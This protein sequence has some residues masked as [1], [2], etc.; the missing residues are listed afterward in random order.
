MA[1]TDGKVLSNQEIKDELYKEI[2]LKLDISVKGIDIDREELK[3]LDITAGPDLPG[4]RS[5]VLPSWNFVN[6]RIPESRLGGGGFEQKYIDPLYGLE[7]EDGKPYVYKY[8]KNKTKIGEV[9]FKEHKRPE[10]LNRLTS[11][12]VPFYSI[13]S[14]NDAGQVHVNYSQICVLKDKGEDCYFCNYNVRNAT[15]KNPKQVAEVF[16]ELYLAGVGKHLNLTSGFMQERR[17][18]E[19]YLDVGEEIKRRTGLKEFRGT[20]VI[21]APVDLSQIEKYKEAGFYSVRMNIEIWDKNIWRAICPG[22]HNH[23]GGWDNWVKALERA[24]EVFGK[25]R[26][27]SNIVGGIESKKSILEGI[28]YETSRGI[29][30]SAS[31]WR[32]VK[33]S[34][35]EGHRTPETYWHLDLQKKIAA[36]YKKYGFTYSDLHNVSP[37]AGLAVDIF[38]VEEEAFEDGQLIPWR[39]PETVNA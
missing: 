4:I 21:G 18:L 6:S 3:K 39:Y 17:E 13:A 8:G 29:V 23:C 22:K 10:I 36:L 27:A 12:G 33:D 1:Q 37:S 16:S 31:T 32:P 11:D 34:F 7:V 5:G 28:E 24:V 14:I 38:H 35:L 30:G 9:A 25:G 26:V 15:I 19:Y 2:E 20:A